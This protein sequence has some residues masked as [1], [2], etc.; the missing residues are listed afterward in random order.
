MAK[1]PARGRLAAVLLA[2]GASVRLGRPK[3]LI[4]WQG[5]YLVKHAAELALDVCDAGVTVV[6]GAEADRVVTALEGL[7]LTCI[8]NRDWESGMGSSLTT[9]IDHLVREGGGEADALLLMLCD[10]PYITHTDIK[11][12]VEAWQSY[13][14]RPAGAGYS[15]IVGVPAIIPAGLLHTLV[16]LPEDSGAGNWLRS[17]DDI[18]VV[19]MPN[20]AIDIDTSKDLQDLLE[21]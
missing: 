7:P 5:K 13:P 3:Q 9:G 2:A 14:D 20:A 10:Q 19:T 17:R 6:T 4:E 1:Q 18:N 16:E 8:Y 11:Q 15:G 12:L 21:E